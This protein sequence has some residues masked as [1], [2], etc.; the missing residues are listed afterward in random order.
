MGERGGN[1][2]GSS[3]AAGALSTR[4]GDGVRRLRTLGWL[5]ARRIAVL[6]WPIHTIFGRWRR[7]LPL[8][9]RLFRLPLLLPP[10]NL[11]LLALMLLMLPDMLSDTD[12]HHPDAFADVVEG[13][14]QCTGSTG[15]GLPGP[16]EVVPF[17]Y[18]EEL[19]VTPFDFPFFV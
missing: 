17:V 19:E 11:P 12:G 15:N 9:L 7:S 4:V 10:L 13:I 5:I 1:G 16:V 8:L 6:S 2:G 14:L 3:E 18:A